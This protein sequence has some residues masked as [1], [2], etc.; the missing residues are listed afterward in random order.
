MRPRIPIL[1]GALAP[2]VALALAALAQDQPPSPPVA[3]APVA[4]APIVPVPPPVLE[5]TGKPMLVGFQCSEEDVRSGG[6]ACS[7]DDPCQIYLELA[8]TASAGNR[9]FAA[10]NI[11]AEAA[12]LYSVLLGS[13]DSGR[14]WRE[15]H[16][17]IR[18][19]GLDHIQ[20]ID[21]ENGL[22]NGL[23][24]SPLPQDPF[25]LITHDGG[26]SW[27]PSAIFSEPRLGSIVQVYFDGPKTGS[28]II[29]RGLG[30]DGDRYE[31][32]ESQDGGD[33]WGIRQTSVKP[34]RLK[35]G[36]AANPD[37]RIRADAATKSFHIEHRGGQ[38]WISEAAFSVKLG[39]CKP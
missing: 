18:G 33:S 3:P 7:E 30:S 21:A 39:I 22:V 5:N 27:R 19:A 4:P 17:R 26:K 28:L 31:L 25:L 32:Y 16:E 11:H 15:V 8:V 2:F 14:T 38:R 24:P 6:L 37:W 9:I 13:E 34:L 10:G 23:S 36:A 20:F 35:S 29:D 1:P 12:T